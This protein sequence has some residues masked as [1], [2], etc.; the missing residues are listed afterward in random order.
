M[1]TEREILMF[2]QTSLRNVGLYTS[3]SFALLASSRFYREKNKAYNVLF[4]LLSL[5][6]L[7]CAISLCKYLIDDLKSMKAN[8]D[9]TKYLSKWQAIPQ[10]ILYI[11]IAIGCIIT[12]TLVKELYKK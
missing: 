4:L 1:E 12:F 11:D 5:S 6:I 3:I 7:F 8:L 9:E 2:Y 10:A